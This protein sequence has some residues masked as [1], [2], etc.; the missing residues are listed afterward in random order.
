MPLIK[1]PEF[2]RVPG[3]SPHLRIGRLNFISTGPV[4]QEVKTRLAILDLMP[5]GFTDEV[6]TVGVEL[7]P[8]PLERLGF[9]VVTESESELHAAVL[10]FKVPMQAMIN[11]G[12]D[13]SQLVLDE[14][15]SLVSGAGNS[16]P[17]NSLVQ[18]YEG[19]QSIAGSLLADRH[20]GESTN[21]DL[22]TLPTELA[23]PS[24]ARAA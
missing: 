7:R 8:K 14:H 16:T 11:A 5:S 6:E 4:I 21:A 12:V 24:F 3:R 2:Q 15:P 19:L 17:T 22:I 13:I 10:S 20:N 1:N 23:V 18:V 9:E